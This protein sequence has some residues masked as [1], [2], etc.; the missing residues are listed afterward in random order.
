MPVGE[1]ERWTGSPARGAQLNAAA[2]RRHRWRGEGRRRRARVRKV[3]RGRERRGAGERAGRGNRRGDT[4]AA[5]S[6]CPRSMRGV[7]SKAPKRLVLWCRVV[8]CARS[9]GRWLQFSAK[10][11]LFPSKHARTWAVVARRPMGHFY[12]FLLLKI[13]K[14]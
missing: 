11:C 7:E 4:A 10:K 5:V 3:E 9:G 12:L 8:R 6:R 14:I 13:N 1:A 2:G